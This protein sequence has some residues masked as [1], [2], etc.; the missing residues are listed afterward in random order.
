MDTLLSWN[1]AAIALGAAG[2]IAAQL[3]LYRSFFHPLARFPGPKLAAAT[4]WYSTYYEVWKDGAL[5]EHLEELHKRYGPVVRITPNELHFNTPRAYADIYSKG[6]RFT[7]DP[8]F[9]GFMRGDESS[10]W[11]TDPEKSKTRRDM[12][13]PL[14]SRRAV[15][16]MEDVVLRKVKALVSGILTHE[17]RNEPVNMLR[18]YRCTTLDIILSYSFAH[19]YR[20][21]DAQNFAHP[22]VLDFERSFPLALVLKS[23]PWLRDVG[24]LAGAAKHALFNSTDGLYGD[25]ARTTAVQIDELLED[26][27]RLDQLAHETVWHRFLAPHNAKGAPDGVRS[28]RK[29][30]MDE[31]INFFAAGSDTV[32][33]TCTMG[34]CFIL[35]HHNVHEKLVRELEE[36][37]PDKETEMRY[38]QLEKLPYL[39]AVIKESLRMSHGVVL[40][41]PRVVGPTDAVIDGVS[42]PAGAVVGM[43]STFMHYNP[44]VFPDPYI[45]NPDRWLQ[46]DTSG[47]EQHLVAFSRGPRSCLGINLAWCEMYHILGYMFRLVD[48]RLYNTTLEDMT[49][50]CH[51]T[52]TTPRDRMLHCLVRARES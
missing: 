21:L 37:W 19:D 46:P 2:V 35:A 32:G 40:P 36:A 30:M 18:A 43:G 38:T 41:A 50:R 20:V 6:I 24:E 27:H 31:A 8:R 44:D 25:I 42:V 47:L 23:F 51:F 1:T 7:K 3:T 9:Y 17:Q 15:L 22:L 39:T 4:Y 45:F 29:T 5:I 33:N 49:F 34:T 13:L 14:F 10:F 16:D 52:V 26:P 11:M 12:L 48:M 28:S